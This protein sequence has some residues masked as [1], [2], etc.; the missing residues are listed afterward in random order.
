MECLYQKMNSAYLCEIHI[1]ILQH[2]QT[3]HILK[4]H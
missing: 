2:E 1:L 3:D 4:L